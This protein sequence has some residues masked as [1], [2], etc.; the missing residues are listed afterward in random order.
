MTLCK[1]FDKN[2]VEADV[3]CLSEG[4]LME[5]LSQ[6]G[7]SNTLIAMGSKTNIYKTV[8]AIVKYIKTRNIDIIHTHTV[9]SNLVGRLAALF[10]GKKCVTHVHS[11]ILRDFDDKIRCRINYAIDTLTRPVA[12]RFI[13]VS[14]SLRQEMIKKGG[15]A[16]KVTTIHN[17]IDLEQLNNSFLAVEKSNKSIRDEFNID[18]DAFLVTTIALLRPRKGIDILINAI[19]P[20]VALYPQMHFL[21]V[22]SDD[23]SEAPHYGKKLRQMVVQSG[24]EKNVTFTGFRDDIMN[25][26]ASADLFVLPSRFGEGLPMVILE[27]MAAGVPVLASR[28][29]GVPEVIEEGSN[30]FM[31]EPENCSDLVEKMKL[32]IQEK[33]NL[34][35]VS[36]AGKEM[37]FSRLGARG[38]ARRVENIYRQVM[39]L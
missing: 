16:R 7:V 10:S 30:G 11:P 36:R 31:F 38:Q 27:A 20:L 4:L 12:K 29:E 18:K 6:A 14:E 3:L 1:S 35:T 26:L 13:T 8:L 37:V 21:I 34:K 22:G 9:R 39:C 5:K 24:V 15:D 25:I 19:S 33:E 23:I 2:L 32:L 17:A 28:V